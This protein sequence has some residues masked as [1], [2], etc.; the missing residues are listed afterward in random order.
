LG[1]S[2]LHWKT[3]EETKPLSPTRLRG[4][5]KNQGEAKNREG[6]LKPP[7]GKKGQW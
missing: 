5:N 4:R 2:S 6:G 7:L 1:D 3:R